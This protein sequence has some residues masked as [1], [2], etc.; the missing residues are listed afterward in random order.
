ME[1]VH[2]TSAFQLDT[3]SLELGPT[4]NPQ[5]QKGPRRKVTDQHFGRCLITGYLQGWYK[6]T[7]SGQPASLLLFSF[8]FHFTDKQR[9]RYKCA[10][11]KLAF[12]NITVASSAETSRDSA[13][14]VSEFFPWRVYGNAIM[15]TK[16]WR[17]DLSTS[18]G[19]GPLPISL[20]TQ[21]SVRKETEFVVGQRLEIHGMKHSTTKDQNRN[22][23]CRWSILEN[24]AAEHGIPDFFACAV[25]VIDNGGPFKVDVGVKIT[26]SL[27]ILGD[28]RSW[29]LIAHLWK[30]DP[31][32]F[33]D[34]GV[35]GSF[36][37]LS[38]RPDDSDWSKITE[39]QW[40]QLVPFPEE[41]QVVL[42]SIVLMVVAV[43]GA[44]SPLRAFNHYPQCV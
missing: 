12:S 40:Q 25:V 1:N 42:R 26:A 43:E 11:I 14:E 35:P 36:P 5:G 32:L 7:V 6:G 19:V 44:N 24:P 28:P 20:S 33:Q 2:S 21:P 10:G 37:P 8:H 4:R 9:F 22:N 17:F 34:D 18:A 31:L 15:E 39:S 30:D 3:E 29:P 23:I 13:P 27:G 41:Y 16:R 38:T